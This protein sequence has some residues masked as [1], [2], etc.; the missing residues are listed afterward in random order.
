MPIFSLTFYAK[1]AL[2][3]TKTVFYLKR[4]L[5]RCI[6]FYLKAICC[7]VVIIL[8]ALEIHYLDNS[9]TTM[10][11]KQVAQ[12]VYD[13]LVNS[14]ANPSSLH[15]FGSDAAKKLSSARCDVAKS[16][17]ASPGEIVFT[18]GG[19]ESDNLA[20]IG[21]AMA[22]AR[23]GKRIISTNGEHAA[24]L[25]SL[26]YLETQGF[27]VR[28]VPLKKGGAPDMDAFRSFLCDDVILVSCMMVNNELGNI[29]PVSEMLRETRLSCP[30]AIFHC[31]AVQAY[32][33][34]SIDVK[35]L[36]VDLMTLSSHKIHGPKG[37][38][39]LYIKK[40]TKVIPIMHGGGQEGAVRS[41][42]ENTPAIFGFAAAA[43]MITPEKTSAWA[44]NLTCYLIDR[45]SVELPEISI[46]SPAIRAANIVNLSFPPYRS[47]VLV[48]FLESRGVYVSSGSACSSNRAHAPF[49]LK[50][51]FS[52]ETADS[53]LRVSVSD[54][55]TKEDIDAL[56][57][58]LA[59]AKCELFG[60]L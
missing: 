3:P 18:S 37:A 31:D 36:G 41:G 54:Y 34:M 26:K 9:A 23:R 10:A 55:N 60:R 48:H 11:H 17:K 6:I 2:L 28:I 30:H 53:A 12:V 21:G 13:A 45:L 29:Y 19:T 5:L 7:P 52:P 32:G 40:G 35:R 56:I 8:A 27:D 46:N 42:T 20:L 33:K 1:C 43:S 25:S 59:A 49:L 51:G 57:D 39:A 58:G 22:R 24:V 44:N 47:E 14:Y 16:I 4:K 50:A 15:S 38:G